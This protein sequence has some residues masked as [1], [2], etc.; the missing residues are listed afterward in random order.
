[1]KRRRPALCP[2]LAFA[3]LFCFSGRAQGCRVRGRS[4]QRSTTVD[5]VAENYSTERHTYRD[6]RALSLLARAFPT[7]S[8]T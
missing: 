6:V 5:R 7:S 2:P 4:G 3:L 1:M 8:I